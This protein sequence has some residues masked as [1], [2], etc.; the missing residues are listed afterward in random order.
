MNTIFIYNQGFEVPLQ[1]FVLEGDYSHLHGTFINCEE[2]EEKLEEL[3]SILGYDE[4]GYPA[5]SMLESFP[6][7]QVTPETI[8]IE[9]G[10]IP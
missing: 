5:I 2:D 4:D 10:F 3:N 6:V 1:Y 7:P 9:V 8:V